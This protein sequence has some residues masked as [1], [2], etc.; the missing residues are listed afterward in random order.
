MD[1]S[2][3]KKEY[4]K[5]GTSYRKLS[6]KYN[7]PLTTLKT[8]AGKEGWVELR[9]QAR[10]K[11]DSKIVEV[12]SNHEADRAKR[13][14]DASDKL[15]ERLEGIIEEFST[16]EVM[17]DRTTLKSITGAL[18]DIKDITGVKSSLDAEEQKARI[19]KL[20]KEAE[21]EDKTDEICIVIEG[22][23]DSWAE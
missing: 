14:M 8:T 20:R 2:Q 16:G 5:G 10:L 18:K 6:K 9:N 11:A 23:E 21:E 19:A 17:L 1:Y 15:L 3:L 22:G 12:V 4:I 13:L 7:V